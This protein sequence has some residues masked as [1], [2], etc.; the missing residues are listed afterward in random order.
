MIILSFSFPLGG[1]CRTGNRD[2]VFCLRRAPG[3]ATACW[4]R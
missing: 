1:H 4:D 2:L 3:T